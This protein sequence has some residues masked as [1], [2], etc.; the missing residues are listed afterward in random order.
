MSTNPGNM[1]SGQWQQLNEIF[2]AAME[3]EPQRQ[4]EFLRQACAG[5]EC[6]QRE[7]EAMLAASQQAERQGFLKGDVFAA[8][9]EVLAANEIPPGMTIGPYRVVEEIGRGGMGAVYLALREGFQQKVALKI[10]K[11]GMDTESIVRRFVMERDVLASLNHPNIARL[12]DGG[13]AN[14]L[15]FI[16][17]EYVEGESITDFCDQNRLTIDE[18]LAL[19]RKVCAAVIYAHQNLV[20]HRDLKPSNILV[21]RDGEPKLL[22]FGIAKLLSSDQLGYTIEPTAAGAGLMTPE[23]ASPE[24]IRGDKVTTSSDIYS[25]GVLLYEMLCGHRPFRFKSRSANEVLQVISERQPAAPSTAASTGQELA[26]PGDD[27][28]RR[29]LSPDT[30][31]E[32][33][34]DK[35]G[36]LKR[37][38]AG[39]L[40][41][42]VLMALRKEPDRRYSSVQQFA[43]DVRRHLEGIPVAARPATLSYRT[44]KF[45]ERNRTATVFATLTLVAILAGLSIAVWQAVVARKQYQRAER[46]SEEVRRLTNTLLNDLQ[47]QVGALPGSDAARRKLS[48]ISI[49]YLNGLARDTNDPA[50]LKQLSAAYVLLGK[51][52]GYENGNP[53]DIRDN[54]SRGLEISRRLVGDNPKDLDAKRLLAANLEEYDFFCEKQPA[55][56]LKLNLERAQLREQLA[57][58]VPSDGEVYSQLESAYATLSYLHNLYERPDDAAKYDKRVK[59]TREREVQLLNKTPATNRE[60]DLLSGVYLNLGSAY[61]EANDLPTAEDYFE[62]GLGVAE[63]LVAEHPD[64]RIGWVRLAAANRELGDVRHSQGDYQ[65]ALDHFQTCLRVLREATAKLTDGQMRGAEPGYM[66]RI[67]ENLYRTGHK[68]EALQM[69]REAAT[70]KDQINGFGETAASSAN[71]NARFLMSTGQVYAVF[72]MADKALAAYREAEDLWEKIKRIEPQQQVE[73]DAALA[74]LYIIRGDLYAGGQA[75]KPKA[76]IEYQAAVD[77]LS[78][79]KA[80]DQI[81]LGGL[82]DLHEAQEKLRGLAS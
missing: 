55:E 16:A 63:S 74:R 37:K 18:R 21:T 64:Y 4:G 11:R 68:P 38:L 47:A 29:I 50:V 44:A 56:K 69:L 3:L 19:F 41:N 6:L 53:S 57:A 71:K 26:T 23:Y 24:Q 45:I 46:R 7:A 70:V 22:D 78:Q 40:D 42:I 72:G 34:S 58:A 43:D 12:L 25:L 39:D 13:T 35:P 32:M 59:Q 33:R 5:D 80:N 28:T 31:A 17:M 66:L 75:G 65:G 30:V 73:A 82:K 62:R 67:A 52:Y 60:R 77:K 54:I 76:R 2:A 10:I 48:Q 36:R 79:L 8:G 20:V 81:A 1:N 49:E 51:Q 15:P 9:A 14:G 27:A 61:V